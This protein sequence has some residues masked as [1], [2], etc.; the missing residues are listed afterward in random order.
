MT[1]RTK[2]L[3]LILISF[4]I[5]VGA[6]I[7]IDRTILINVFDPYSGRSSVYKRYRAEL[8]ERLKLSSEQQVRLDSILSWSRGKFKTLTKEFHSRITVI[9]N[10]VRDSIRKIL[11]PEQRRE[12]ERM[13]K[14]YEKKYYRRD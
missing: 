8:I 14:E 11:T 6:G 5:G 13:I 10:E 3:I 9:R 12:F 7:F 2:A 4:V 1:A